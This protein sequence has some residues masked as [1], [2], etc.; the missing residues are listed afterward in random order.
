MLEIIL[1]LYHQGIVGIVVYFGVV[2][3]TISFFTMKMEI[4]GKD[5]IIQI[6]LATLDW[7]LSII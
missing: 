2:R 5:S 6:D 4:G 3:S 7:H 1:K